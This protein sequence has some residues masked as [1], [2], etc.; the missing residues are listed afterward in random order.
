M[1][2][3]LRER[4]GVAILVVSGELTSAGGDQMLREAVDTLMGSGR[5]RILLDLSGVDV[6]DSSGLGELVASFRMVD[7]LGGK[8]KILKASPKVYDT[9]HISKLLP[10]FEIYA[11]EDEAVRSFRDGT[12]G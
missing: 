8:L 11:D 7:K 12:D 5:S 3:D 10:V 9:L 2:L 4:A 1:K 6:L